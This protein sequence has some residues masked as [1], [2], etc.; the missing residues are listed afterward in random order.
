M[1]LFKSIIGNT[2]L[3]VFLLGVMACFIYF[4]IYFTGP[5]PVYIDKKQWNP[6]EP[7]DYGMQRAGLLLV[8]DYIES[9]LP[10]VQGVIMIKNGRTVFEKYYGRGGPDETQYVHAI[11]NTLLAFLVGI[12]IDKKNIKS[13]NQSLAEYFPEYDQIK[14]LF[15]GDG[16]SLKSLLTT[17]GPLRWG[18][19]DEEYWRL[20]Y[21][22][23]KITEALKIVADDRP[24]LHSLKNGAAAFL[25]MEIINKATSMTSL[26]YADQQ[27]FSPIGVSTIK[28]QIKD[29]NPMID[30]LGFKLKTLDLAKF[31]YLVLRLGKWKDN[32][33]VS[34]QWLKGEDTTSMKAGAVVQNPFQWQSKTVLGYHSLQ[35]QGEGG[36]YIVL[37]P[38]HD[39]VIAV[40]SRSH[41][42]LQKNDGYETLFQLI[43]NSLEKKRDDRATKLAALQVIQDY[44]KRTTLSLTT[45]V[46]PDI[47][48]FIR[49]FAY[50]VST[51]KIRNI[52]KHYA[53]G[54]QQGRI[55]YNSMIKLW[56]SR[57]N[58]GPVYLEAAGI[59]KVRIEGNRAY[60]RGF[61][62]FAFRSIREDI[63]GVIAIPN[64]IKSKGR[65]KWFGKPP[66]TFLLDRDDYF[67]AEITA[68]ATEFLRDCEKV[69]M[70]NH[71][72]LKR[73]C[74]SD[75]FLYRGT[76]GDGMLKIV[77][78]F[79]KKN[80]AP[81][82]RLTRWHPSNGLVAVEGYIRSSEI[83]QIRLP[84]GIA[85]QKENGQWRWF[86]G[87]GL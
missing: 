4:S 50:D 40:T 35:S 74:F 69:F 24:S 25:L 57:L 41:F 42:P 5:K 56:F 32:Q 84:P 44:S 33:I 21:A 8:K 55:N 64:M 10:A 1:K 59:S 2:L 37:I 78:S 28:D 46:P 76:N 82:I 14:H 65:W 30:L 54:Y 63:P 36:Q 86:G 75:G 23:E 29:N 70:N 52:L 83:G 39:L 15:K 62:S 38:E 43:V 77:S 6:A 11:N 17:H 58:Q 3:F 85:L 81:E 47:L 12:A 22:E 19:T 68:D 45:E 16:L 34:A 27:L 53:K 79:T 13:V 60:L 67:E 26:E 7:K 80:S 72:S 31:G 73:R 20:F 87:A 51:H 61:L 66:Y 49:E 71:Y 48:A 9:K 18:D